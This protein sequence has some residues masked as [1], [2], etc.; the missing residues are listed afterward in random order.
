MKHLRR[1]VF[2][3]FELGPQDAQEQAVPAPVNISQ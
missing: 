2:V 3:L 1:E